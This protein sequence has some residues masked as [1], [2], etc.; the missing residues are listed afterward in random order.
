M[1]DGGKLFSKKKYIIFIGK[2]SDLENQIKKENFGLYNKIEFLKISKGEN[3]DINLL[4][5]NII[6]NNNLNI[7]SEINLY[8]HDDN[9]LE[10]FANIINYTINNLDKDLFEKLEEKQEELN[11]YS[12]YFYNKF[13]EKI[14]SL[15]NELKD[16]DKNNFLKIHDFLEYIVSEETNLHKIIES[17]P[18]ITYKNK[19]AYLATY[20]YYIINKLLN[21]SKLYKNKIDDNQEKNTINLEKYINEEK[22][23]IKNELNNLFNGIS[24]KLSKNCENENDNEIENNLSIKIVASDDLIFKLNQLRNKL[25]KIKNI[26]NNRKDYYSNFCEYLFNLSKF[27]NLIPNTINY[28]KQIIMD[29]NNEHNLQNDLQEFDYFIF[30][31]LNYNFL[32]NNIKIKK[33]AESF[34]DYFIKKENINIINYLENDEYKYRIEN[35]TLIQEN[36]YGRIYKLEN[37]KDYCLSLIKKTRIKKNNYLNEQLFL[38]FKYQKNCFF[39]KYKDVYKEYFKKILKKESMKELFEKIFPYLS[40]NNFINDNF[41]EEFFSKIRAF[42]FKPIELLAETIYPALNVYIKGYFEGEDNKNSEICASSAYIILILHELIHYI[43]IYIYKR[44]GKEEYRKS[45]G[46]C[47]EGEIGFYF[48]NLFFGK[49]ISSINF[50]QAIFLLNINNYELPYSKFSEI[51]QKLD[52]IFD[53]KQSP[54]NYYINDLNNAKIFLETLGINFKDEEINSKQIKFPIK[55]NEGSLYLGINN[56]KTGRPVILEEILKGTSLEYLLK[57]K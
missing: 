24:D 22:T 17:F 4:T 43:R 30:Y 1:S 14:F 53:E 7:S 21:Y 54:D 40:E 29:N 35:N 5:A 12:K 38:F 28:F 3:I 20:Y 52:N 56:D 27:L 45:L 10:K 32:S 2:I 15:L 55:S 6:N 42:N 19:N 51:F 49:I 11:L 48:E 47:Q 13:D 9:K 31:V 16:F 41:I 26:F 36:S 46:L 8:I 23:K 25:Y 18:L 34:E 50:Y 57:K 39:E 44:T 33:L 37:Y